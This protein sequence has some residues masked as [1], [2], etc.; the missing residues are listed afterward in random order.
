MGKDITSSLQA[1]P[2][3]RSLLQVLFV[4]GRLFYG[5]IGLLSV[6]FLVGIIGFLYQTSEGLVVSN[7]REHISWGYYIS[8]FAFLVGVAAAAVLLVIPA[9]LYHFKAIKNIVAFGEL[10]AVTAVIM[11]MLFLT[12]DTG[13]PERFWHAIPLL[14][15]LNLPQS[16]LGWDIFVLS[17]YLI[18]NIISVIYVAGTTYLGRELNRRILVPLILVSIPWA[19][20]LHSVTA[21]IFNGLVARPFWNASILAPRFLA[22]AFCSGP[23]IMIILFQVLRKLTNFN[24]RDSALFKLAEIIAYAMAVNIFL[25]CAEVYKEYYSDTSLFTP[26]IYLFQGLRGHDNLVPWIWTAT[27]FNVTSFFLLIYPATRKNLFTLNI[28][29]FLVF[30]GIWIEKGMGLIVPG[31]VPDA[32]GEIYEYTPSWVEFVVGVGIWAFGALFYTFGVRILIAIDNGKFRHHS[33]PAFV[34]GEEDGLVAADIM[35]KNVTAVYPDTPIA[36]IR[37]I[38]LAK[39]VSGVPVIDRERKVVG[40]VSETDIVFSLLHK[41]EQL[42]DTLKEI[43]MP[44]SSKREKRIGDVAAEVMS[45]PAITALGNTPLMELTQ[46]VA[47]RG[48]KRVIIV[49]IENR[50]QGIVTQIDIVKAQYT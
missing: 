28:A 38:L 42:T 21:F 9:Y 11:S 45:S 15:S 2:Q 24:L 19:V 20:V 22:S 18:I 7:M 46:I 44:S 33:A 8:N 27:L 10:L 13:R 4:G 1:L 39:R 32:L 36:E 49:D 41:E 5:W 40:V 35:T 48:I 47:E 3:Q 26:L 16:I 29:C 12:A 37:E 30:V 43:M 34:A 23:A 25:L 17:G 6:L 14:G 31:F 50:L